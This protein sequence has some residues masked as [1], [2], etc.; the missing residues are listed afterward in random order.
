MGKA[1]ERES[2]Q[3]IS[4]RGGAPGSCLLSSLSVGVS[5]IQ[6]CPALQGD[7]GSVCFAVKG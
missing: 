5:T 3:A 7:W 2:E 1:V 6:V 4:V